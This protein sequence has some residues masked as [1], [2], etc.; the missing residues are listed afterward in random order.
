MLIDLGPESSP[1]SAATSPWRKVHLL[2]LIHGASWVCASL[3]LRLIFT[4]GMWGSCE[5]LRELA[6]TITQVH[7]TSRKEPTSSAERPD[8]E[9]DVLLAQSNQSAQT[10]DG[11]DW[12]AERVA[13]EVS[14]L[15]YLQTLFTRPIF[16]LDTRTNSRHTMSWW[17]SHKVLHHG[18]QSRRP[19]SALRRGS[20]TPCRFL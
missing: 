6:N 3:R 9:L 12:G 16:L 11:I 10:Y 8:V 2:V 1:S 14:P 20:I 15:P 13:R 4:E 7:S 17:Q 18:L 5:H 19:G